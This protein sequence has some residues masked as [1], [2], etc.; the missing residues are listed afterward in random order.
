L[1]DVIGRRLSSLSDECNRVLSVASVIGRDFAL[2]VLG[3]VGGIS[4]DQLLSAIEE[5]TRVSLIEEMRGQR[6]L[7]YRFT[8]AFFRQ[9]LYEEMIAP[10]RLRLHNEVAKALEA[11]YAGRIE[12]HAAELADHFAH[13]SSEE[14]LRKAIQYGELAA[15][16]SEAVY[17]YGEAARHLRQALE[18]QEVLGPADSE[19]QLALMTRLC[20]A[21][22]SAGET[23]RMLSD[24]APRAFEVAESLGGGER[25]ARIAE[26]ATWAIIYQHGS[27]AF[28]QPDYRTWCDRID[29]HAAPE[30]RERVVADDFLSWV[31]WFSRDQERCWELR[32]GALNLA[33]R[34][35][36]SE[37][38]ILAAFTFIFDGGPQKWDQERLEIAREMRDIPRVGLPPNMTS[39]YLYGL[40]NNLLSGGD[41]KAAQQYRDELDQYARRIDE[42]YVYLWQKFVECQYLMTFGEYEQAITAARELAAGSATRGIALFGQLMSGY[43]VESALESLG[44]FDEMTPATWTSLPY[45][46]AVAA[47]ALA[48]VGKH[49]ESRGELR[50]IISE[51]HIGQDDWAADISLISLLDAAVFTGDVESAGLLYRR[52]AGAEDWYVRGA[53]STLARPLGLAA[54]L[55]GEP[56]AARSHFEK[57][58]EIAGRVAN[59]PDEARSRVSLARLLFE[60]YPEDR[61]EAGEHLS[62]ATREAQAL[63]MKPLLDECLALKLR[64]QGITS[65]D[66]NTSIDT[67][68]R[69]FETEKPDLRSHAAPDGTV[70]IMFSDIEDS[71]VLTERLGDQRWQ[72]LLREHD[73]IVRSSV[74]AHGG[75]V[76]KHLG[77]GFMLAFQSARKGL[78]AAIDIQQS[79]AKEGALA[80]PVRVRIGLHA[81]EAV[82]EKGDF[83]GK[84]VVLASRVAGQAKGGEILVSSVLHSL[85]E[86]STDASL[87]GDACEVALK[88]LEGAH[89]VYRVRWG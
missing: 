84:N 89:T 31:Y 68:A 15:T 26:S 72:E 8:H 9:T 64:F 67:V 85:V 63:K 19:G 83:F 22:L 49:D 43:I 76:V 21:L 10:R 61:A 39:Q 60:H 78:D 66:I 20:G 29:A 56:A 57:A 32:R 1:K 35:G 2:D 44:R 16:R 25:A 34:L 79:F 14:D 30:S 11:H 18:V 58:I 12:E 36:D 40:V 48:I 6:E 38:L 69:A 71:T 28:V 33:R 41:A 23:E 5:A 52:L 62:I 80:E 51:Q 87:F 86:S 73:A 50:R 4:E 46:D 77:D 42:P 55:I 54:V 59:R 47:R 88:G 75:F 45:G 53:Y 37:A 3:R 13:S 27:L 81:G 65:T 70:T 7:R 82:R 74:E 17:A 24:V